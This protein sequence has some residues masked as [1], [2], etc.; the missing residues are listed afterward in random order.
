M[1]E[2]E[3]AYT[4][5]RVDERRRQLLDLGAELFTSHAYDKLTMARIAKEA[6]IS[7]ALLY[8]YFPSKEAYF[9]ATLAQAADQVAHSIEPDPELSPLDAIS[10]SLDAYLVW[11]EQHAAAYRK[12]I[13]G[14]GSTPE[15][16]S[17]VEAIR[18]HTANRILERTTAVENPPPMTRA[19]V[20][21]WLWYMD[22]AILDW[23]EHRDL[24]RTELR[25]FLLR[26]LAGDL[27]AAGAP[28]SLLG[29]S[30]DPAVR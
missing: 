29:G 26:S 16:G 9:A 11:I 4:R 30:A 14:V 8:H 15:V 7:K 23:L 2:T 28:L 3:P 12:L 17:L 13:E 20:R 5:L 25:D 18:D 1:A 22:G 19:A 21:A 6:G 10:A 24:E 27:T